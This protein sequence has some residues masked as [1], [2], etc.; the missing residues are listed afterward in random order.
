MAQNL[1][2]FKLSFTI[3]LFALL[4]K[5]TVLDIKFRENI[6][7]YFKVRFNGFE[8]SFSLK[9][10]HYSLQKSILKVRVSNFVLVWPHFKDHKMPLA[11]A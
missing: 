5:I 1:F 7:K 10:N 6:K 8:M 2:F 4:I 11:E 9:I 3:F